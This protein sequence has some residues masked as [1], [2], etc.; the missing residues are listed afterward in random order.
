MWLRTDFT[1]IVRDPIDLQTVLNADETFKLSS[2]V[3][4]VTKFELLTGDG[5]DNYKTQKKNVN[6]IMHE[7]TILKKVLI[8]NEEMDKFMT[9]FGNQLDGKRVDAY[10][11]GIKMSYRSF[12]RVLFDS[13]NSMKTED[14]DSILKRTD[15]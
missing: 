15:E 10:D 5:G 1:V 8:I 4:L 14:I 7:L 3:D 2:S 9:T 12:L 13:N 6:P 11:I